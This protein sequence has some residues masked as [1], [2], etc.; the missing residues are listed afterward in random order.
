MK[1]GGANDATMGRRS[2]PARRHVRDGETL[3]DLLQDE[4]ELRGHS[5]HA[6]AAEAGLAQ[7][8]ISRWAHPMM[9]AIPI[10]DNEQS[11]ENIER[12]C[13]YLRITVREYGIVYLN[14]KSARAELERE[15]R[16]RKR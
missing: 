12:L 5:Q 6:A 1:R 11:E 10:P 8:N 3:A 14:S 9:K 16:M 13:R 2:L 4:M 15:A 7:G